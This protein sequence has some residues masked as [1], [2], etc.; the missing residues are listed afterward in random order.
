MKLLGLDER[1]SQNDLL[2][3]ISGREDRFVRAVYKV[4]AIVKFTIA[5]IL[6]TA[7]NREQHTKAFGAQSGVAHGR[8]NIC[9]QNRGAAR[10]V[11]AVHR[12]CKMQ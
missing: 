8:L 3:H 10:H 4:N 1:N 11:A 7:L 5:F 6:Y 2:L 12:K 9:L